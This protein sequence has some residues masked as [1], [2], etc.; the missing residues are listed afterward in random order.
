MIGLP[1]IKRMLTW[2]VIIDILMPLLSIIWKN[3]LFQNLMDVLD[4]FL[5]KN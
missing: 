4:N 2:C 5:K 1:P 3:N